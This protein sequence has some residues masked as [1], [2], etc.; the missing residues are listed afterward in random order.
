MKK[1]AILYQGLVTHLYK[2]IISCTGIRSFLMKTLEQRPSLNIDTFNSRANS[3][4]K[5]IYSI[6]RTSTNTIV[7]RTNSRHL[8]VFVNVLTQATPPYLKLLYSCACER[9]I[10]HGHRAT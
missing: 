2:K 3:I 7:L 6:V 9:K 4:P 1:T 5:I 10:E 8:Q